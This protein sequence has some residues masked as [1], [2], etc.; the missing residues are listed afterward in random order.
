MAED[1]DQRT[2]D[3]TSKR[4][5]QAEQ[6][7]QVASSQEVKT[8]LLFVAATAL[9][10]LM[11]G[12]FGGRFSGI[13]AAYLDQVG[14]INEGG[15]GYNTVLL[16]VA[17]EVFLILLPI[18]AVFLVAGLVA[19]RMQNN[20]VFTLEKLKP[21]LTK[22]SPLQGVKK[23]ISTNNLVEF[24]KSMTKI[25]FVSV[26]VFIVVWPEKDRLDSLMFV[27]MPDVL[28]LI[29]VLV[30]RMFLAVTILLT[31]IAAI[32]YTWQNY[33]HRKNLMMTKQEVKD[34]RKQSDG[35]PTVKR[36]LAKIRQERFVRRLKSIIPESDVIITN[37][38]H[39]AVAL[40]YQ[41]GQMD[42]PVLVAKGVDSLALRIRELAEEFGVPIV[43]NPPLARS[44]HATVEIDHEIQPDQYEAVAS[45]IS[46][47]LKLRKNGRAPK[48]K[49]R[50][51]TAGAASG[52]GAD[53][54]SNSELV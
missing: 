53:A 35:D 13:M 3:P 27:A 29:M 30:T 28:E 9:L 8:W 48:P 22:L 31:I 20:F 19:N 54:P 17:W 36:R 52:Q 21:D 6:K 10:M 33:Q 42:V 46:Y 25:I 41:H 15:T 45:V 51:E 44:L 16:G 40:K 5:E 18:L 24:L 39:Y 12:Y 37:P 38:T 26:T 14:Q 2:E 50:S 23:I 34:E 43:E 49:P 47:V 1:K 7:G 11:T 4:L 32:D